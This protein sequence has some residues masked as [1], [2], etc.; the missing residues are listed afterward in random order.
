MVTYNKTNFLTSAAHPHIAARITISAAKKGRYRFTAVP[1]LG[2]TR[3]PIKGAKPI[4]RTLPVSD[5]NDV[6]RHLQTML[7]LVSAYCKAHSAEIA[8]AYTI[9][10]A[11]VT[12]KESAKKTE[13]SPG[14]FAAEYHALPDL[15]RLYT[16][17]APSTAHQTQT[18]FERQILFRLDALR[19]GEDLSKQLENIVDALVDKAQANRRGGHNRAIAKQSV[20]KTLYRIDI[21]LHRLHELTNHRVPLIRFDF[22]TPATPSVELAK[23]LLPLM[24]IK[25]AAALRRL[26]RYPRAAGCALMYLFGLRTSEA[27][28]PLFKDLIL[29]DRGFVSYFVAHQIDKVGNR[30]EILKTAAAYRHTVGG[31]LAYLTI[32]ARIEALLD[33]GYT[34]EQ[35]AEMPVVSDPDD[36]TRFLH[37]NK[38]SAYAKDLLLA[39]GYARDT[40]YAAEIL[41]GVEPDVVDGEIVN[42]VSCYLL[43]RDWISRA[44]NIA[45]V[46]PADADYLIGHTRADKSTTVFSDPDVRYDIAKQL[47]SCVLLADCTLHP[48]FNPIVLNPGVHDVTR[49]TRY[50][51][52]S[53]GNAKRKRV[54]IRLKTGEGGE[55]MQIQTS[56]KVISTHR[57]TGMP[58]RPKD[59]ALRPIILPPY[60][61]Q[62]LDEGCAAID[63]LDLS[64]FER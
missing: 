28:A 15:S 46:S 44:L 42:D 5:A 47:D 38:L 8:A 58:D 10:V 32:E 39:C 59:R 6:Q 11:K 29:D 35:I 43:R 41:M 26:R 14:I 22:N 1:V 9:A 4:Q 33:A 50:R 30:T 12:P 54:V 18:Y 7:E 27:C 13:Q 53:N 62:M 60:S 3:K 2:A 21:V 64:K 20:S 23:A 45:G 55:H 48:A 24:R 17:W 57:H 25:F 51:L 37:P 52:Q 63:A 34:A 31:R 40:M 49:Y 16:G 19:L 61:I 36:P 56:G